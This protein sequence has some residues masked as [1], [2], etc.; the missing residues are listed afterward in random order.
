MLPWWRPRS[1]FNKIQSL[2]KNELVD[3]ETRSE[4]THLV[5]ALD[6]SHPGAAKVLR[7][8]G[9][10]IDDIHPG[11]SADSAVRARQRGSGNAGR[12]GHT[13]N[14][15]AQDGGSAQRRADLPACG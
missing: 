4:L 8:L 5:G 3:H 7:S 10:V 11:P 13:S 6:P 12:P 15:P 2:F 9:Q 1:P 14:R